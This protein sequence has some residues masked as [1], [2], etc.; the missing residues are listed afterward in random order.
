MNRVSL[1]MEIT[2]EDLTDLTD[3]SDDHKTISVTFDNISRVQCWQRN[4]SKSVLPLKVFS[5]FCFGQY[6]MQTA[7]RRLTAGHY[8]QG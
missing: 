7:D 3:Q 2:A 5:S 6:K 8:F 1:C 4:V